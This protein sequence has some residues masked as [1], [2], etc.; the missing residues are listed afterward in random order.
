MYT[1][2]LHTHKLVV[3]I[4]LLHYVI[5]LTMLLLNRKDTLASYT[6]KTKVAEMVISAL[7]LL[8]GGLMLANGAVFNK[9]L[10]IK[11]VAVFTSIPL[12]VI[13]FKKS[14][15]A[16]AVLSVFLIVT[17]Y[18]LAEMNK[19][20]KAGTAIDTSAA[21]STLEAGKL[22]YN[23]KCAVCHGS[24]GKL[25]SSGAKDLTATSLNAE[26]QKAMIANGKNAM[27]GFKEALTD[28]QIEAVVEY[29]QSL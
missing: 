5:K 15:K 9:F 19:K 18:G 12:A 28:E 20:A 16:L 11:L 8:T 23:E 26:E 24:D 27:P 17:A 4:F 25:G 1:G 2:L 10:I 21:A 13:G 29:V 3:L 6:Q 7:F 14:N 22:I